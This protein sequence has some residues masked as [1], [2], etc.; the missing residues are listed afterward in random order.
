MYICETLKENNML[1]LKEVLSEQGVTGVQL[2]EKM[3]VTPQYISGIV[4][5]KGSA[6]IDVLSKIASIL[7][8]PISSLFE[9]YK[10]TSTNILNCP[11]CGKSI[12]IKIE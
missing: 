10:K 2:A 11:H 6:S 4:R 12:S 7:G 5:E 9:D 1:R 8:V 3:G